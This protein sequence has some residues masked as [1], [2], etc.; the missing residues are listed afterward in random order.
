[1]ATALEK[2]KAIRD[3]ILME[4]YSDSGIL[5]PELY[6]RVKRSV[7]IASVEEIQIQIADMEKWRA[8]KREFLS[9]V[10]DRFYLTRAGRRMAEKLL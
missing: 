1:M 7:K 2:I 8:I 6:F 5:S 9:A 3:M 10:N 4:I